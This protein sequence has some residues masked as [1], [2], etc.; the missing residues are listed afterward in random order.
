MLG[1]QSE[2]GAI[3]QEQKTIDLDFI[4]T[5]PTSPLS[6]DLLGQYVDSES[7]TKVIEPAFNN[8][9]AD[10]RNSERGQALAAQMD[11]VRNVSIGA[12]AP[13]FSQPDTAGNMV[14]LSDFRGQYVLLDFWASWCGPCRQENPNVVAA[15]HKFKD[16]NFTILG[17]SLDQPGKRDAWMKAIHDDGLQHWTNVSELK[18]WNSDVVAQYAIRGIPQNFLLDPEGRIVAKN[19]RGDALHQKLNEILN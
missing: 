6:L 9:S 16:K 11:G 12:I 1:L 18:F 14:S 5:N 17:I 15:Y 19:L 7:L 3:Q 8:L 10:L 4:K 2:A 13:E